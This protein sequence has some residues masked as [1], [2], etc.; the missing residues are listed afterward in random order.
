MY[1]KVAQVMLERDEDKLL[2]GDIEM[3]DAYWGGKSSGGKRGRG[4][5]RRMPF[6]AAVSKV[7]GKPDQIKLSVIKGFR[8]DEIK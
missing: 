7:D 4:A 2:S 6:L 8:T 5:P 3:D 1:H